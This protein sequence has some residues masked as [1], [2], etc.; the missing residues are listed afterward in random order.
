MRKKKLLVSVV[1]PT[2]VGKTAVTIDL[3]NAFD[4]EIISADSRQFYREMEL[5][6][7]KP[8][9]EELSLAP[10]HFINTLSVT[11]EYSVGQFEKDAISLLDELFQKYE[12]VFMAGGSGLFVDAVCNGLDKFPEI[13]PVIREKLNETYSV[14]GIAH[15][16]SLL[17]E[18]DPTYYAQVDV[19]NPQ[20]LIRALEVIEST[21]EPFSSF[22]RQQAAD[23]PFEVLRIGLE[24]DREKLYERIDMRMDLMI[25][26]GLF[27][28]AERLYQYRS[29][30][31]L[32]TVGYKEIFGHLDGEYD[33]EEAVRLLKRNSRRYA[34]RQLTWFRRNESVHWFS[35]N[36]VAEIKALISEEL[37]LLKTKN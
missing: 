3:A 31:A 27:E 34:K 5:G 24:M 29:L 12:V 36:Q 19:Q 9:A 2:A 33:K 17:K 16:Q 20:R 21:G 23:R 1:G 14:K 4:S 32:Q 15:L 8:S 7:A 22:R 35:P 28:E 25:A 26:A 30:N 6:T 10:H 37:E 18:K 13:D 11:Q